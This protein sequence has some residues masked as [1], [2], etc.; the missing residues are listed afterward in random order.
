MDIFRQD[1]ISFLYRIVEFF[2][3]GETVI[4][5][6]LVDIGCV[7]LQIITLESIDHFNLAFFGSLF[8]DLFQVSIDSCTRP[9]R[10]DEIQPFR[11][12]V[13]RTGGQDLHLVATCQLMAERHQTMV[14]FR[15]DTFVSDV[16]VKG[17]S[18]VQSRGSLRQSLDITF[19]S[20]DKYLGGKKIQ[21][22]RVE[23]VQSIRVRAF[24]YLGDGLQPFVE[25]RI[26][27]YV[28]LLIFPMGGKAL[29]G[30]LV[31]TAAADLYLHPLPV[32]SHHGQV[33]R[34]VPVG[35]RTAHPVADTVRTDTVDIRDG[36]IDI[37]TLVLLVH[38]RQ[39]VEDDTDGVYIVYVF[40]TDPFALHLVPDGI[41]GFHTGT[42]F[43]VEP[44]LLQLLV[45]R[46]GKMLEQGVTGCF[47]RFQF[48]IDKG[49]FLRMFIL[50]AQVFQFRLD[51]EKPQT[52]CQRGIEV[53]RLTGYLELLCGQ[54]R[55]QRA[56]VMKTVGNL[57]QDYPDIITHRQQ[58]LTEILCLRRCLFTEY[59]AG[60]LR[61][62]VHDLGDLLAEHILYIFHRV[63]GVLH[64]IVQQSRTNRC[65]PQSHL[66]A[67]NTCHGYRVHDVRLA[68]TT[69]HT[70][71]CLVGKVKRFGY[72]L[73]LTPVI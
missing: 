38:P 1:H 14:D 8:T 18:E 9:C 29:L 12:R 63:L 34:L 48:Q 26:L 54:H 6:Q 58:Q 53:K 39:R 4:H 45:Y 56:H 70:G 3:F 50:E 19:R 17:I 41:G 57:D 64:H 66:A 69:F 42:H 59:T 24:Q 55:A 71:M 67:N 11:L 35:F 65:G 5:A 22:D 32:R 30:D 36:G 25:L 72:A 21:F 47:R 31:H 61:Q 37:P 44:H 40:K 13:L 33:Q 10:R 46:H 68:R 2:P 15:A 7:G 73:H 52:V 27:L 23:E 62:A 60:Y 51:G 28:M 20:K 49:I 43:V 16:R